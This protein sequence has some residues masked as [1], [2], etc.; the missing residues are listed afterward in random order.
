MATGP[1][2]NWTSA[3]TQDFIEPTTPTCYAN[4]LPH[5]VPL[6][7]SAT[8]HY[9]STTGLDRWNVSH[10][11]M[12]P[13][14]D[15]DMLD[16]EEGGGVSLI[17][18]ED[19]GISDAYAQDH[20]VRAG[21]TMPGT[22]FESHGESHHHS[23]TYQGGVQLSLTAG[24]APEDLHLQT[25]H[26]A[27]SPR[28]S[29]NGGSTS[30]ADSGILT[31]HDES[32]S[33]PTQIPT[34]RATIPQ[35]LFQQS[36]SYF[37]PTNPSNIAL[38]PDRRS[39]PS[40]AQFGDAWSQQHASMR[41][42]APSDAHQFPPDS[43]ASTRNSDATQRNTNN[44]TPHQNVDIADS[45]FVENV[46]D[47]LNF[48]DR[49]HM[50]LEL[51]EA[52]VIH[53]DADR[54]RRW[55]P[56]NDDSI[57]DSTDTFRDMQGLDWSSLET[58]RHSA[59]VARRMFDPPKYAHDTT[60][61]NLCRVNELPFYSFKRNYGG[62]RAK[63]THSQLRHVLAATSRNDIFYASYNKVIRTSL[64]CP[65]VTDTIIGL[66]SSHPSRNRATD[67]LITTIA[68]SPAPEFGG[69]VS[70]SILLTGGFE[71]EYS[72]LN[73]NSSIS[74]LPFEGFV[75]NAMDGITTHI[76][77]LRN[78]R[79]GALAAA[80]CSNDRKLRLLDVGTN[81]WISTFQYADQVNCAATAP[82]GRLRVVVG[83]TKETL[84]TDAENGTVLFSMQY[85]DDD[86]FACAWADDGWHVAT[87]AQDGQVVVYDARNWSSPLTVLECEVEC[88]R[89]LQFTRTGSRTGS[90]ALV[91][92]EAEDIV[93]IYDI[94]SWE[95][96]QTVDF[97][98][99]VAGVT[100]LDE[101]RE[102]VVANGDR[103][104]GGLMLFE[105][106][107]DSFVRAET[108][109]DRSLARQGAARS[110]KRDTDSMVSRSE[111]YWEN[112][113]KR[114]GLGIEQLLI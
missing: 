56:P 24:Q 84:I 66:S 74:E 32:Q 22:V 111:S 28:N 38:I 72:L 13:A 91:V 61:T 75:T 54:M 33:F 1:E 17:N 37:S 76:H 35:T 16:D 23:D 86:A 114:L 40:W 98:G 92:A 46:P 59:K 110:R 68:V 11:N 49:W 18:V 65:S 57:Q 10:N 107:D 30:Y 71:G 73:L 6:S 99:S 70:D 7:E 78:R 55:R 3:S 104:V 8:E 47:V 20:S 52:G 58:T 51:P 109:E 21:D 12:G 83:D 15:C 29:Y 106:R 64:A 43:A 63:F 2:N 14:S 88:A 25:V 95:A 26:E 90:P 34:F 9:I 108:D 77:T 93:S 97:F 44:G 112:Q 103:T 60:S 5:R 80:F 101:G 113:P 50:Q 41:A 62:H 4:I 79:N 89:S 53:L 27:H 96:K 36:G 48:L 67:C 87:G 102:L 39:E 69:Y 31:S 42:A 45:N 19:M 100:A 94:R 105:R 85:H 81:R 82:D